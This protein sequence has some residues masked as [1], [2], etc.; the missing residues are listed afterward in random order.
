MFASEHFV[1]DDG[2][3]SFFIYYAL[4]LKLSWP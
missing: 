1:G 3:N 2:I 4:T